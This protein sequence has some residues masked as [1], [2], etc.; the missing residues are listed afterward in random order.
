MC[1]GTLPSD[2]GMLLA[3]TELDL[4]QNQLQGMDRDMD[5]GLRSWSFVATDCKDGGPTLAVSEDG[6][7]TFSINLPVLLLVLCY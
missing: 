7:L 3:L 2:L 5:N 1:A 6:A 4:G